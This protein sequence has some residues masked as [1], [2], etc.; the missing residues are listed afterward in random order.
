[1]FYPNQLACFI[2][3]IRFSLMY[4]SVPA[5][6]SL[7]GDLYLKKNTSVL[8][9]KSFWRMVLIYMQ[10]IGLS[11]KQN[12]QWQLICMHSWTNEWTNDRTHIQW[13]IV[14]CV[15]LTTHTYHY[16]ARITT[17][18]RYHASKTTNNTTRFVCSTKETR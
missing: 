11:Q 5:R 10:Q 18:G 13:I 7:F 2:H 3:C 8:K 6:N 15:H 1:M 14:C 16:Y 9:F 12:Q 4:K 17:V